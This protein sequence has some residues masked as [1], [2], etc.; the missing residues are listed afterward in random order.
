[1]SLEISLEELVE[2]DMMIEDNFSDLLNDIDE[3]DDCLN[4]LNIDDSGIYF[5]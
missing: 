4:Q 1:M 2:I 5:V 3:V